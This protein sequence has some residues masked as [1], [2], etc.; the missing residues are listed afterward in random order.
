MATDESLSLL[1]QLNKSGG[2]Q[3][4]KERKVSVVKLNR[5]SV[6][7]RVVKSS[8]QTVKRQKKVIRLKSKLCIKLIES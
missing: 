1:R 6:G 7:K 8:S 2:I 4:K 3:K 5:D